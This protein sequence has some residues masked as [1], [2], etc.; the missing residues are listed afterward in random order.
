MGVRRSETVGRVMEGVLYAFRGGLFIVWIGV[1]GRR[2]RCQ[3]NGGDK[4]D[5]GAVG[6]GVCKGWYRGC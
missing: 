6:F 4:E 2:W 1:V 3:Q 5:V